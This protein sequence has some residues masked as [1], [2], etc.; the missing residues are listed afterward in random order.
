MLKDSLIKEHVVPKVGDHSVLLFA[1][2]K[3]FVKKTG[4]NGVIKGYWS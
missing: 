1:G 3:I 2:V 4:T